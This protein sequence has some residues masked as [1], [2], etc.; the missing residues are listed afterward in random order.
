ML[1]ASPAAKAFIQTLHA[2]VVIFD[3]KLKLSDLFFRNEHVKWL[4]DELRMP[5]M[6]TEFMWSSFE[7][8]SLI[9]SLPELI[10]LE[11]YINF[12]DSLTRENSIRF[13]RFLKHSINFNFKFYFLS[14]FSYFKLWM[15]FLRESSD[16]WNSTWSSSGGQRV[17]RTSSYQSSHIPCS[18]PSRYFQ[19]F[20]D[21]SAHL[22]PSS[23]RRWLFHSTRR[24]NCLPGRDQCRKS[25]N[26]WSCE[27]QNLEIYSWDCFHV[28]N[29][30]RFSPLLLI[31][32]KNADSSSLES[33][34]I[35]SMPFS[36]QYWWA[37]KKFACK[38][39][40]HVRKVVQ[41]F[42]KISNVFLSP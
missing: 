11:L 26:L 22:S 28:F 8:I 19:T 14:S 39:K 34:V 18:F 9:I 10:W 20:S 12:T 25:R 31:R 33:I 7:S 27:T 41:T 13:L 6:R 5:E 30:T 15:E 40:R 1:L 4:K 42:I 38:T 29:I 37:R 21:C 32:F 17:D 23:Y 24:R 2:N 3:I 36:W 35:S 16:K